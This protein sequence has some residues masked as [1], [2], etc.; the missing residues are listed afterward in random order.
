MPLI[1]D[2]SGSPCCC[3]GAMVKLVSPSMACQI[4]PFKASCTQTDKLVAPGFC[5]FCLGDKGNKRASHHFIDAH[6]IEESRSNCVN[7]KRKWQSEPERELERQSSQACFSPADVQLLSTLGK[8][9]EE[10]GSEEACMFDI[11][12]MMEEFTN[13]DKS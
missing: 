9:H 10:I 7:R 13:F 5:P 8:T 4:G 6:S 1:I 2:Y 12:E 3:H 11:E